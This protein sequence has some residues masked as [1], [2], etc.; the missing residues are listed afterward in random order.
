M[1]GT[2]NLGLVARLGLVALLALLTA[3]FAGAKPREC[4][5]ALTLTSE[6]RWGRAILPAGHY[7][8][9]LDIT[10]DLITI[11]GQNGAAIVMSLVH[12]TDNHLDSSAV[13]L[14]SR[15]GKRI[16]RALQVAELKSV[17]L[18]SVP[19]ETPEERAQGPLQIQRVPVNVAA[20]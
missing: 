9:E 19:K 4:V 17:F 5:G 3:G 15:G 1:K 8:F 7:T 10:N 14:V 12:D 18:Y 6:V 11:N 2:R 16:V 13:I 20:K